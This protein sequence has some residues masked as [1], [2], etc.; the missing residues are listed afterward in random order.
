MFLP[1]IALMSSTTNALP[2]KPRDQGPGIELTNKSNQQQTFYFYNNNWNG[3]GT[4]GSNF[5][6]PMDPATILAPGAS[7]FVSLPTSFKGRVQRGNAIPATWVEFQISASS[8]NAAHG[9]VS[10]EQGCDGAATIS[11]MD[12]SNVTGGFTNDV[13]STAPE[14]ALYTR[15]DG[16][17]AIAST[18]GNWI[19]GP[20]QAAI[21]YLNDVVGQNMAYITGGAG[22]P[23]VTSKNNALAVVFY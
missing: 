21:D 3:D 9:D 16:T 23:D 15:P 17:K 1:L 14:A 11:S 7:T 10:L 4:A 19:A 18:M 2:S 12:G 5:D 8:D 20:N 6:H 22:V 13:V